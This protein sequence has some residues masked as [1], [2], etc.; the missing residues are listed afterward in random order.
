MKKYTSPTTLKRAVGENV[1]LISKVLSESSLLDEL[2]IR[3]Y[4]PSTL[5]KPE[6]GIIAGGCRSE[7]VNQE[8]GVNHLLA[9]LGHV[10]RDHHGHVH[11]AVRFH[12]LLQSDQVPEALLPE[13]RGNRNG[14]HEQVHKTEQ[15]KTELP[16]SSVYGQPPKFHFFR[17]A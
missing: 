11:L 10:H 5:V 7:V 2:S 13:D 4:N 12:Y 17:C 15:E 3:T 14:Y 1:F 8:L 16:D 6:R 9:D